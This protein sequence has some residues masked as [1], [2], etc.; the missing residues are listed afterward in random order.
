MNAT[1][2]QDKT[3]LEANHPIEEGL[4]HFW[5]RYGPDWIVE[6]TPEESRLL[7]R[8]EGCINC[9]LCSSVCEVQR[10]LA[11]AAQEFA[12]PRSIATCL[13]RSPVDYK[14][15]RDTIYYCTMCGACEAVCPS[16][17]PT[18]EVVAMIRSKIWRQKPDGTPPAHQALR[19]NIT[20]SGNIYGHPLESFACEQADPQY[21]FFVGCVGSHLER[22]S[23]EMALEL[24]QRL[25]VRVT[26]IQ[27]VCCGGPLEVVGMPWNAER[28]KQNLDAILSTGT[29]QV[30][31][32]CPRCH[33]TFTH[34]PA[35][36]GQLTS[37]HLTEFLAGFNW[38]ALSGESVTFH[39]PCELGRHRGEYESVR[40]VLLNALPGFREMKNHRESGVCCG[41]GGGL[42]GPQARLSRQIAR[43]RLQEAMESGAQ[44][45]LTECFT[46]L[47]NF[48]NAR[49]SRDNLEVY[50]L[51]E[52]LNYILA[53]K[54]TVE[55]RHE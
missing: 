4:S 1:P 50:S 30:L 44:V 54:K 2:E 19:A 10:T 48:R 45:L 41:A 51:A 13:S 28:A 42:R 20:N 24:L 39:D 26:T 8:I 47:H 53:G 14:S 31:T 46:C 32:I 9:G 22:K 40:S 5:E 55:E 3:A 15:A 25:D 12:G 27:E 38:Q 18:P 11:E 7:N 29:N 33:L 37:Q 49:R 16:G 36:A 23:V 35:Y 43:N 52:Y 6:Y 34:H 21:V 17:V